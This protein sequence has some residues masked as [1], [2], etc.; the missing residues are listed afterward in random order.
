MTVGAQQM[1]MEAKFS[2]IGGIRTRYFEAGKGKTIVLVHGG[3]YG[4]YY[5]AYSWSLNFQKLSTRYHVLAFDKLGMGYTDNPVKDED[6]TIGTTLKHAHDFLAAKGVKHASL[7][8]H[9]RGAF[10][11]I[12]L[13]L[14]YPDLVAKL[15][16]ADSNTLAPP[17]DSMI[18]NDFYDRIE[19]S[20][21]T[22]ETKMSVQREPIAN[23][24]SKKHITDDFAQ[25]LLNVAKPPPK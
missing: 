16:V 2:E 6:Y 5:N 12:R 19:L 18:P 11:V 14:E 10:L 8:G 15:I 4:S 20:A 13:A 24:Y 22:I 23:S 3:Q 7:I 1:A 25:Q 17:E 9:S 21:P